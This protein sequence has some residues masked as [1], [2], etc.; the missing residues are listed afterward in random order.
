[1]PGGPVSRTPLGSLPPR[2]VNRA[3]SFRKAT[4][5]SSSALASWQPFT[6]ANV[7]WLFSGMFSCACNVKWGL[8]SIMALHTS[9][10]TTER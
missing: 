3:G 7:F 8:L 6:S 10:L 4:I 5:S 1:M 9:G 2:R